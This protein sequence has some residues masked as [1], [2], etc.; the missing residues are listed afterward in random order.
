MVNIDQH[1]QSIG[2]W[3]SDGTQRVALIH[4]YNVKHWFKVEEDTGSHKQSH[5]TKMD[6]TD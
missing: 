1:V 6:E 5:G 4:S 2:Q 3:E